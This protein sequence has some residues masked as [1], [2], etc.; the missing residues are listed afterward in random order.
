M[1]NLDEKFDEEFTVNRKI[2]CAA[3]KKVRYSYEISDR[4]ATFVPL[5][6]KQKNF[7]EG[8]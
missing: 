5:R 7:R 8:K 2:A 4:F 1:S 3:K 6:K